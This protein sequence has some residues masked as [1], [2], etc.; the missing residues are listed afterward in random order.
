MIESIRKLFKPI[1]PSIKLDDERIS[2]HEYE[3][4]VEL[5]NYI[6]CYWQLKTNEN[7]DKAYSYRVVSDGC[8]DIFF[9]RLNP[10]SNFI[11]GFCRKYTAFEIGK[12]FNFY[13]VRFLPTFFPLLFQVDAK[14]LA[15][16]SQKLHSILPA[17]SDWLSDIGP[18]EDAAMQLNGKFERIIQNQNFTIDDRFYNALI[19]ILE[20]RGN[21]D[22]ERD[23]RTGLSPRHLRRIFNYYLGTTPKAFANV[24]RFQNILNTTSSNRNLKDAKLYYDLGFYDQAHFV[25]NFKTFYGVSPS[26]AFG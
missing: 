18:N 4:S 1:Q 12:S 3:P 2:Y 17:F 24:V 25:K 21:I 13:G 8:I 5:E 26:K 11:M 20:R 19:A 22:V 7:L 15:N 23:L 16:R 9:D 10:K 6:Y 14:L